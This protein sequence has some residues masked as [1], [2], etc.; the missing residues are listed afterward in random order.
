MYILQHDKFI[1]VVCDI[2]I[3]NY[4]AKRG[5]MDLYEFKNGRGKQTLFSH[6]YDLWHSLNENHDQYIN[7]SS[8]CKQFSG[9]HYHELYKAYWT[10]T[11]KYQILKFDALC[12]FCLII[13]ENELFLLMQCNDFD[14]SRKLSIQ[15]PPATLRTYDLSEEN[16]EFT[17]KKEKRS[18]L[19]SPLMNSRGIRRLKKK[20]LKRSKKLQKSI[21]VENTKPSSF[22]VTREEN[23][24]CGFCVLL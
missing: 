8:F 11:N 14:V 15:S 5:S 4:N 3:E 13:S 2:N 23:S 24:I 18:V 10:L 22:I 7:F 17:Y 19:Q 6:M 20:K 12:E 9:I 1:K 21:D 16:D